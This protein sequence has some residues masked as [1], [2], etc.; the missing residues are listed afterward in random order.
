MNKETLRVY[1]R[2][3]GVQLSVSD[4]T[5]KSCKCWRSK[6]AI[7]N[8]VHQQVTLVVPELIVSIGKSTLTPCFLWVCTSQ[9][10]NFVGLPQEQKYVMQSL[11]WIGTSELFSTWNRSWNHA[12]WCSRWRK[13]ATS[14]TV[15]MYQKKSTKTLFGGGSQLFV[16]F[17]SVAGGPG[18]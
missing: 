17:Q 1:L 16:S 2:W 3:A 7:Y 13:Q 4:Y 5:H 14:I 6:A 8:V 15:F 11:Q 9:I 12:T 10:H 18:S